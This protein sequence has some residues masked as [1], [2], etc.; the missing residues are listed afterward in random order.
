MQIQ[1]KMFKLV[2]KCSFENV[3]PGN[4]T[5]CSFSLIYNRLHCNLSLLD[6]RLCQAGLVSF[7]TGGTSTSTCPSCAAGSFASK[8]GSFKLYR[9]LRHIFIC[10]RYIHSN[11]AGTYS[12]LQFP[13]HT[14]SLGVKQ[15][16]ACYGFI[17]LLRLI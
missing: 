16:V 7:A 8:Y 11:P 13:Q 12:E 14:P 5:S 10:R 2:K 1:K 6:C 3:E 17:D 4:R 9:M 15:F